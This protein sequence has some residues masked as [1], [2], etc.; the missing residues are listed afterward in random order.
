MYS[1]KFQIIS[2]TF[3]K[4]QDSLL[5]DKVTE[6]I[7]IVITL[8]S[9]LATNFIIKLLSVRQKYQCQIIYRYNVTPSGFNR[10]PL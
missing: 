2:K 10:T 5:I 1:S 7:K 9:S 8:K 4:S 6:M 3:L